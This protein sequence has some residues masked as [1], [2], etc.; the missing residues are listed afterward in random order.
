MEP[1]GYPVTNWLA[2]SG[3]KADIK[4][5]ND[6]VLSGGQMPV[7][8]IIIIL[9]L[10]FESLFCSRI[11]FGQGVDSS[12]LETIIKE[13]PNVFIDGTITDD[14]M[15]TEINFVNFVRDRKE[16]DVY[17]LVA[18]QNTGSGGIE[19]TIYYMGQGRFANM[20]D[21]LKYVSRV[22][23]SEDN[24]RKAGVAVLKGGLL[25]YVSRTPLAEYMAIN[26]N[27]PV[28]PAP[29]VDKWNYWIFKVRGDI[30][31]NGE[32]SYHYGYFY[33]EL[34]ANRVTEQSK[35]ALSLWGSYDEQRFEYDGQKS[36]A[37][38]RSKG[39][40]GRIVWSAGNH[41][42]A[43]VFGGVYSS[44]YDNTDIEVYGGPAVEYNLYPYNQS[45]RRL[46]TFYYRAGADY[47]DYR[48]VT[49]RDKISDILTYHRLTISLKLI[50][51]WGSIETDLYGSSYFYDFAKNRASLSSEISLNLIKGFSFNVSAGV[52][53]IRD[54]LS[55]P[56]NP[57]SQN[58]V[59]L[60][61]E[62]LATKY[63]YWGNIGISYS[64]GS[65]YNNIVNPRFGD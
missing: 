8:R 26:Y 5:S 21:T 15:R 17:I 4:F 32:K 10:S 6:G 19:Y 28:K 50:Q 13:A 36:L 22:A 62:Q 46:L 58:D 65:L 61:R 11:C 41:W 18:G 30:Y 31:F 16:A 45:T 25:R 43:G 52:S 60:R 51:P 64:F 47:L 2:F 35:I 34:S 33:G 1:G 20:N 14:Y 39:T 48:E 29:A 55:L 37:L 57:P 24:D 3:G 56:K 49:I 63:N 7:C 12:S 54:Q 40:S 23:E 9:A 38:S 44:T 53:R 27:A 59:F 42:S